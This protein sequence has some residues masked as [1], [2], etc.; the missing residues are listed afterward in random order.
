[1]VQILQSGHFLKLNQILSGNISSSITL[2][3]ERSYSCSNSICLLMKLLQHACSHIWYPIF[4]NQFFI[5]IIWYIIFDTQCYA[6]HQFPLVGLEDFGGTSVPP[7]NCPPSHLSPK[8]FVPLDNCPPRHL[9]PSKTVPLYI[10]PPMDNWLGGQMSG[11][12]IVPGDSCLGGQ[13]SWGTNVRGTN[14]GG[15]VVRGTNVTPPLTHT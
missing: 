3:K 10:C 2:R 6:R 15:T 5:H 9:S 4:D 14:V 13:M 7:D 8:T 12:T 1:M 11:G